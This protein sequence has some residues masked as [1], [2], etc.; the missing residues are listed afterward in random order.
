MNSGTVSIA[1]GELSDRL[2]KFLCKDFYSN[3]NFIGDKSILDLRATALFCSTRTP[4]KAILKSHDYAASL[5]QQGR[6][7]VGGFQSGIEK[8]SLDIL[9]RGKQPIIV[10]PARSLEKF[11]VPVAWRPAI[12]AGRLLLLSPFS[13]SVHRVTVET[14]AKRNEFVA[15]LADEVVMAHIEPGGKLE[16]LAAMVRGWGK[17]LRVLDDEASG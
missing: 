2:A 3:V 6:V 13:A 4:G 15:A 12:V 7:V 9:M 8:D 16:V 11:R 1:A 5:R 10:C 14:A 17:P